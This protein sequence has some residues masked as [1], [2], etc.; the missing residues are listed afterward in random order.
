MQQASAYQ[1]GFL[2]IDNT[3]IVGQTKVLKECVALLALHLSSGGTE[4]EVCQRVVRMFSS[5]LEYPHVMNDLPFK[6]FHLYGCAGV[7]Y[8][9]QV[10]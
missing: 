1:R 9:F 4:N 5:L 6:I 7:S 8:N 2:R 3:V 10:D